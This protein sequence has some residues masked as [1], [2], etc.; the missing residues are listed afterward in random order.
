[1]N[2][3]ARIAVSFGQDKADLNP[4]GVSGANKAAPT[5]QSAGTV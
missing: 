2:K 1:M 4:V 3:A 5:D